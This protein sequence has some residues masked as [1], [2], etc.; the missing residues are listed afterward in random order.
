MTRDAARPAVEPDAKRVG[1][2]RGPCGFVRY[3]PRAVRRGPGLTHRGSD[4]AA[5]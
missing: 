1:P 5:P 3:P 2:L 4:V